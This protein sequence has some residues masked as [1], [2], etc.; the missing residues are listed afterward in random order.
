[1]EIKFPFSR[2]LVSCKAGRKPSDERK[3]FIMEKNQDTRQAIQRAYNRRYAANYRR[4]S[5]EKKRANDLRYYV[6]QLIAAGYTVTEPA[7]AGRAAV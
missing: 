6:R 1:M 4:N 5:P 2:I 7:A 3:V